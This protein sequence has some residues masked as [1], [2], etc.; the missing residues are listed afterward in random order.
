MKTH[1]ESLFSLSDGIGSLLKGMQT[2]ESFVCCDEELESI[3]FFNE[4]ECLPYHNQYYD[5]SP[6]TS[7]RIGSIGVTFCDLEGFP[8]AKYVDESTTHYKCCRNGPSLPPFVQDEAFE[9]TIYPILFFY[10]V[11]ALLSA[12]I[13]IGLMIPLLL[14]LGNKSSTTPSRNSSTSRK[15]GSRETAP[16]YS[17]F[18]LYL[19]YLSLLDFTHSIL[20][21]TLH[22]MDIQQHFNIDFYGVVVTPWRMDNP[23]VDPPINYL[24]VTGNLWINTVLCH[25]VLNFLESSQRIQR[26]DP[27]SLT[28]VN[29]QGGGVCVI[30]AI[31]GVVF[32]WIP[33]S[34]VWYIL[35]VSVT[36]LPPI[37]YVVYVTIMVIRKGYFRAVSAV[38]KELAFYFFRIVAVFLGFWVPTMVLT[39]IG[40]LTGQVWTTVLAFCMT[41]AQPIVTFCV[42]LT[43][44]DARMY[45]LDFV[46]LSYLFGNKRGKRE[47]TAN[48]FTSSVFLKNSEEANSKPFSTL[49]SAV[50]RASTGD[51]ANC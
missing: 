27:P 12:I 45:I 22:A 26:I 9:S 42:I 44:S 35:F 14:E 36:M 37:G 8:N 17:T 25:Q 21:I 11:A 31:L 19:V 2:T 32:G 51:E 3:E 28:K 7:N 39:L 48:T 30:S 49:E 13:G 4:T 34:L 6:I 33:Q 24:Y 50:F 23:P 16:P 46:T 20:Q 1:V 43:K 29:L 18:N 47:S 5:S 41:A 15:S 10:S 40:V 38:T